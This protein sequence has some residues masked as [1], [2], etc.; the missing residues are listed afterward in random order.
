MNLY[1]YFPSLPCIHTTRAALLIPFNLSML[2]TFISRSQ[3]SHGLRHEM[4][5]HSQTLG[6]WVRVLLYA[7]M[8]ACAVILCVSRAFW[9]AD[10]PC[11]E[12]YRLCVGLENWKKWPS[13]NKKGCRAIN[14][15]VMIIFV[16]EHTFWNSAFSSILRPPYSSCLLDPNILRRIRA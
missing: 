6:S 16:E 14:N 11:K 12:P 1:V 2:I 9:W 4:S 10:P 15:K 8:S 13:Y 5:L 7:W 3:W